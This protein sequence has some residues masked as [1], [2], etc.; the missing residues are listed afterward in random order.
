MMTLAGAGA[1]LL[2]A[3]PAAADPPPPPVPD[4]NS[5]PPVSPVEYSVMDG[6]FFAFATPDGLTCAFDRGNGAYG[7]SG[8]I[9]AAPG[10]ANVVSGGATVAPG[11]SSAA[12]PIFESLGEVKQLPPNTR[13]SYRT[14]SCATDGAATTMCVNSQNQTGFV[15]S[16]S[17]SFTLTSNPLLWRPE[18]TNPYAN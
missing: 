7:C 10:G 14:V 15:L 3:S 9:P 11:F 17:G 2:A 12:N 6:R 18:G 5:L 13:M 1:V 4:V 8:P 16:P